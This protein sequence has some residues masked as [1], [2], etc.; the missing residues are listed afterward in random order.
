M[1][2]HKSIDDVICRL[3]YE[4]ADNPKITEVS[5]DLELQPTPCMPLTCHLPVRAHLLPRMH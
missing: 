1:A 2:A 5:H 4:P 3:C